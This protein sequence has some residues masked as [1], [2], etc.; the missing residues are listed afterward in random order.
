MAVVVV[1]IMLVLVV[2]VL[3]VMVVVVVVVVEIALAVVVVII[4]VAAVLEMMSISIVMILVPLTLGMRRILLVRLWP[5]VWLTMLRI[6]WASV[7]LVVVETLLN[8]RRDYGF[9]SMRIDGNHKLR[10]HIPTLR[11]IQ[12]TAGG[13]GRSGSTL[14]RSRA[15][16]RG[17]SM[18]TAILQCAS[19][20]HP[21]KL[22]FKIANG[23][24]AATL[25]G[26]T[27]AY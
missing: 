8:G 1:A 4:V 24:L 7:V 27:H 16:D 5:E 18:M 22:V 14:W 6:R 3:V 12:T 11:L 2:V 17:I 10:A 23:R 20:H 9:L 19:N 26:R 15:L 13:F 25:S 21:A